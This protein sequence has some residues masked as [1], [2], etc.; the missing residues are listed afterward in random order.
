MKQSLGAKTIAYPTP[1]FIIGS[2]DEGGRPNLMTVSWGGIC[3]SDPPSMAISVRQATYT[4][5]NISKRLAYTINIPS[6]DRIKEADFVGT[7]SGRDT[8]KFA[9]LGLTAVKSELVDA[10]YVSEFPL[11]IE[12]KVSHVVELGLHTQFVGEIMDVKADKKVLR[13]DGSIDVAKLR[14][15]SFSPMDQMYYGTG[16]FLGDAF[17]I[18]KKV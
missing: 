10:P 4:H 8:D 12:C 7:C 17:S 11:V 2:Y 6:V 13:A 9:A 3:C 15:F 14:P 1:V 18:G 16:E 5:A